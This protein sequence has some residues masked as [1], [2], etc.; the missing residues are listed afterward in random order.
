MKKILLSCIL[1]IFSSG[2]LL[3]QTEISAFNATGG[4]YHTTF[5]S[6]YQCLGVNP[7]NLGWTHND[8]KMNL[9]F[10][11][12]AG[13]IYSEPLTKK[14]VMNDLFDGSF[15]LSMDEKYDA[16]EQF[17]DARL[18]GIGSLMYAGFSYQDEKIGGIA[19]NVRERLLWNSVFNEYAA[20]FLFLGYNDPYFDSVAYDDGKRIG[21]STNPRYAS[22]VYE[23]TDL[24]FLHTREF[25]LGYGREIINI[26]DDIVWYGGIG[27]KYIL[28]YAG[29]Q[30]YQ[31]V[32]GDLLGFSALSPAYG[33]DYGEDTPSEVEGSGLKKVGSGF[34]F[35]IGTTF[36]YKDL[37]VGLAVNDIGSINWN[38]DVYEG[39]DVKVYS[40]E[41][42]GIDSYNLFEEGELIGTDNA[43]D[44]PNQ[45]LG[46]KDKKAKLPM[47][48]RGGVSYD[49]LSDLQVGA[50]IYVPLAE[51]VPGVY[52]APVFGL[53]ARYNPS[54]GVQLSLGVVTGGKF[55]TNVPFGVT[56]IPVNNDDRTWTL[57]IATRD[58]MTLFTNNDPTLSICFGFLR[59]SFGQKESSTRYLEQ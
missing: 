31:Q 50:D 22:D 20:R 16:A 40:I 4:G 41:T 38:G 15:E 6:D 55:G 37:K 1:I 58:L 45:W 32:S 33:V 56:F 25:S 51:G 57:G 10:F 17:T 47:N 46:L 14:Q 29:L 24:H 35:D 9:G 53:G 11:E 42:D 23:G 39:Y 3:S 30:Y 48:L 54:P 27:L 44:D 21:I 7:A 13:S 59:F 19:F 26:D 52:E 49:I 28:G 5:L 36:K 18:L 34:G 8:H 43:P 12:F 2:I